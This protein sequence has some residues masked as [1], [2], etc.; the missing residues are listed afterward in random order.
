MIK[1]LIPLL[2][3]LL[4]NNFLSASNDSRIINYSTH[5]QIK[6]KKLITS[7]SY[8][9]EVAK[10]TDD[11][12]SNVQIPYKKGWKINI[13]EAQI[14]DRNGNCVRRLRKSEITTR[15]QY[16]RGLFYSD[17][18]VK[19]FNLRWNTY[20]Y[21][22]KYSYTVTENNFIEI[23][24]WTPAVYRDIPTEYAQLNLD[25]QPSREIKIFADSIFNYKNS[26]LEDR[27]SH[28]WEIKDYTPHTPEAYSPPVSE[29]TPKVVITPEK[30]EFGYEGSFNTWA[31]FGHWISK[32]NEQSYD[33]PLYEKQLFESQLPQKR[34]KLDII[35]SAYQFRQ[36]NTRYINVSLKLGNLKPYSASYVSTNKYGDCKALTC[37]MKALLESQ[38]IKSYYTVI[39]AGSNITRIKT[40]EVRFQFNHAILCVPLADDT[41]WIENT[42]KYLPFNQLGTFTQ[43]RQ[44]LLIDAEKSKLVKTPILRKENQKNIRNL[45]IDIQP[46][47]IV[48]FNLKL[49]FKGEDAAYIQHKIAINDTTFLRKTLGQNLP[50]NQFKFHSIKTSNTFENEIDLSGKGQAISNYKKLDNLYVISSK[51]KELKELE[52]PEERQLPIR[53]NYPQFYIDSINYNV[54]PLKNLKTKLPNSTQIESSFGYYKCTISETDQGFNVIS[55]LHFKEGDYSIKKYPDFFVFF[56]QINNYLD[57]LKT[58]ISD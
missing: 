30:F 17:Y 16:E 57:Q 28:H 33:L 42:S 50:F 58:I 10:Q 56:T 25:I 54:S 38:G 9:I 1:R 37:Y 43:N 53:I 55:E 3:L 32:L 52:D 4:L 21:R 51:W 41:I 14:M 2:V 48:N 8:E 5:I 7:Y 11:Y 27:I 22:I 12:L 40:N 39:N 46:N 6:G 47:S 26:K 31:S 34:S 20:P 19:T 13:K 24:H 44:A 49:N 29:I 15:N 45:N 23:A 18:L 36:K 35:K